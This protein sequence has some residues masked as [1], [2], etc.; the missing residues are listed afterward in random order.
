V[1]DS[2]L[3]G[4]DGSKYPLFSWIE[5]IIAQKAP[6]SYKSRDTPRHDPCAYSLPPLAEQRRIVAKVDELMAVLD[7]LEFALKQFR[8]IE[9]DLKE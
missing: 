4:V 7:G 3:R 5:T 1:E 8:E 2:G 6:R 9:N